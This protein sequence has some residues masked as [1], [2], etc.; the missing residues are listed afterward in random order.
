[1]IN[2]NYYC[3]FIIII[4]IIIIKG[5]AI[6]LVSPEDT[7]FHQDICSYVNNNKSLELLK[8][9]LE[10]LPMLR[11]RIKLAKKVL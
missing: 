9:N 5:T 7:V 1:M 2:Y 10:W 3:H 6:S 11:E 4:I 8:T